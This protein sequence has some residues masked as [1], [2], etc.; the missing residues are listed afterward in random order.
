LLI[1]TV[2]W[3]EVFTDSNAA[4]SIFWQIL[5]G[6]ALT[7]ASVFAATFFSRAQLSGVYTV[8]GFLV[9]GVIG[10]IIDSGSPSTAS[11]AVLSFIFPSMNYM[12]MIGYI[13]RYEQQ[14][15]GANLLRAAPSTPDQS[16][17]SRLSGV[18][19]LIF[20]VLQTFIYP[21]LAI[22]TDRWLHGSNSKGRTIGENS[23]DENSTDAV[24]VSALS[25]IYPRTLAQRYLS[26]KKSEDVV[27]VDHLNMTAQKGQIL[28]LLGA[29]GSGKTTTLNMIGGLQKLSCG[30][31]HIRAQPS[32][33]GKRF[34][35]SSSFY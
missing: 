5:N 31:V 34:F 13:G 33:L 19:I 29:N 28:C 25:K 17:T 18:A 35:A 11:V 14:K 20:L 22:L 15:L 12:F 21:A 27:A 9:V 32:K 24:Q 26:R 10:Q 1:S 3:A 4:I 2:F 23:D 30:S 8:V 7:S 16:S 6:F